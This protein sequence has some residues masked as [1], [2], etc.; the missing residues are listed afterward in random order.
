MFKYKL[1][2]VIGGYTMRLIL[3]FGV[4]I[5]LLN[6]LVCNG[7]NKGKWPKHISL[8]KLPDLVVM[9]R[10]ESCEGVSAAYGGALKEAI[11][12]AGGCNF[13][14]TP[15]AAGGAKVY[16]DQIYVLK[17]P[18]SEKAKWE[19]AGQLPVEVANG[20]S[21]TLPEGIV[22]IGGRNAEQVLQNVWLLNW[23]TRNTRIEV[24]DLPALPVAM[25]NMV[26]ATDGKK[27]YVAGGNVNGQVVNKCFVLNGLQARAWEEITPYPGPSR[28]QP[29]GGMINHKF[30]LM[31]GF[32]PA[33]NNQECIVLTNGVCYDPMGQK[34]TETGE[35]KVLGESEAR[36][37]VGASGVVSDNETM[38]FQGGVNYAIFKAAVD[39]PVLQKKA[40]AQQQDSLLLSLKQEQADYLKHAPEWYRFN[41]QVLIYHP[42]TNIC[43]IGG[44]FGELAKAGAVMV[45]YHDKLIV[46]NGES[47][48]GIRSA[49]AY[50]IDLGMKEK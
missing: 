30:Y 42:E 13:P 37:L 2:K 15:A 31:G 47:K 45:L 32:Q 49:G 41:R 1:G 22:C 17:N 48:P 36:A 9:K 29:V 21:V 11:V 24:K 28:L 8:K 3:I 4:S 20:A 6:S 39:N 38:I 25:D 5:L 44:D 12:V 27:I 43:T 50:M 23:N 33:T 26:A 14:D 34:W 19:K 35:L 16:Y 46:V 40:I 18:E 10:G 7:V